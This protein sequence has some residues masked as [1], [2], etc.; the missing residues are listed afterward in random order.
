MLH[1]M[2]PLSAYHFQYEDM[3]GCRAPQEARASRNIDFGISFKVCKFSGHGKYC[4]RRRP[5]ATYTCVV[6][7]YSLKCPAPFLIDTEDWADKRVV[8]LGPSS[9]G[10]QPIPQ[11]REVAVSD[12]TASTDC[13]IQVRSWMS[14]CL[15]Y[16]QR[17]GR[18]D[19]RAL[20]IFYP[21]RLLDLQPQ[22]T[23]VELCLCITHQNPPETPYMTLSHY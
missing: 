4:R 7:H 17:C 15:R 20:Y 14:N 11:Q 5:I 3:F 1:D 9:S 10:L 18:S 21:T 13:F 6:P 23:D 16:H 19:H 22:R 2:R 12:N 8:L